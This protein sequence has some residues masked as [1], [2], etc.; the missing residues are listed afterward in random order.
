[1]LA[2][3]KLSP[4][5]IPGSFAS[6]DCILGMEYSGRDSKGRRVMGIVNAQGLASSVLADPQLQWLVP[7]KWTLEEAATVPVVYATSY[8]AL[9]I[10]GKMRPGQSVLIHSGSGGVGQASIAIALH[11]GC[12]VITTTK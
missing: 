2:S 6:Q 11:A 8:Y 9:F 12:K 4:E 7:D 10:R 3:G 5:A 1:M